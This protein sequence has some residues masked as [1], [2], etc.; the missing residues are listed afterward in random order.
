VSNDKG[1]VLIANIINIV[2]NGILFK[3]RTYFKDRQ[4][5]KASQKENKGY[6]EIRHFF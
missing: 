6:Y 4:V 3:L 1:V 5:D 2:N